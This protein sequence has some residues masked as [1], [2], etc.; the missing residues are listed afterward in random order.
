MPVM[1]KITE[2]ITS[3]GLESYGVRVRLE[4]SDPRLLEDARITAQQALAGNLQFIE[5]DSAE[6]VFR[7]ERD[8]PNYVLTK[9]NGEEMT[10]AGKKSFFHYFDSCLRLAVAEYAVDR[11]FVHAG[12]VGWKGRAIMIPGDSFSGKTTLVAELVKLGAQYYSDEYAVFDEGGS[13]HPFARR[14]GIRSRPPPGQTIDVTYLTADVLGGETGSSALPVGWVLITSFEENAVWNPEV[15]TSG[16]GIMEML[17]QTIPIRYAPEFSLHVLKKIA[18]SAIILKS[19]RF[20]AKAFAKFFLDFVDN[21][22]F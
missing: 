14:L 9:S 3:L 22:A 20:D 6:H 2:R 16:S 11:V 12:V 13:V 17:S 15:L 7:F 8:G 4:S 10:G 18:T 19:P 5:A 21:K 1:S